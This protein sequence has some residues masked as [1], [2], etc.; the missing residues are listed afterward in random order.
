MK[1]KTYFVVILKQTEA[2]MKLLW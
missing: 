1:H 2:S